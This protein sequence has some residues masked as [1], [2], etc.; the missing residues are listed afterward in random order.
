MPSAG[1]A[2]PRSGP[3]ATD[4]RGDGHGNGQNVHARSRDLSPDEGGR[5]A[6]RSLSRRPAGTRRSGS[7]RLRLVRS[8]TWPQVQPDLRG[9]RQRGRSRSR[10][11]R[12]A[13]NG[14]SPVS[15]RAVPSHLRS[16]NGWTASASTW[17]R[18]CRLIGTTS[19]PSLCCTVWAARA[20]RIAPSPAS[21]NRFWSRSMRRLRPEVSHGRRHRGPDRRSQDDRGGNPGAAKRSATKTF[22]PAPRSGAIS[23]AQRV[24][25]GGPDPPEEWQPRSGDIS[26]L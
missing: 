20:R 21:S 19:I 14:P 16:S 7:T 11:P 23:V 4:A 13:W 1:H 24:S 17:C 22:L 8:G 15:R 18:T 25:A 6:S 9:A 10:R 3:Q 5:C 12:S 26:D 2:R